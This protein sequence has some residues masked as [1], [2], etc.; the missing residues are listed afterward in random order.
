MFSILFRQLTYTAEKHTA[1][2]RDQT[3]TIE[4]MIP[5]LTEQ[6][7][8]EQ[9]Q[10]IESGLF[11]IFIKYEKNQNKSDSYLRVAAV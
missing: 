2:I 6:E 3:I 4:N 5:Q 1:T 10:E 11:E 8:L 9:Y 7:R